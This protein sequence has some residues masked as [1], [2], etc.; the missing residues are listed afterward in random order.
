MAWNNSSAHI[1]NFTLKSQLKKPE[2]NQETEASDEAIIEVHYLN[3]KGVSSL[4]TIAEKL[5]RQ[6][7]QI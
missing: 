5:R 2:T 3:D 6:P 4:K 1:V 7:N